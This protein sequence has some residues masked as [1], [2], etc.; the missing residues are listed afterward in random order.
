MRSSGLTDL[1]EQFEESKRQT[2]FRL[3]KEILAKIDWNVKNVQV[4]DIKKKN[5]F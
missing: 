3:N 1:L 4:T 2:T 5:S